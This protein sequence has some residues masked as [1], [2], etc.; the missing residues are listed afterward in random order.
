MAKAE[1]HPQRAPRGEVN[2]SLR[3][4]QFSPPAPASLPYASIVLVG[5]LTTSAVTRGDEPRQHPRRRGQLDSEEPVNEVQVGRKAAQNV[6]MASVSAV[7]LNADGTV[8][9]NLGWSRSRACCST[10]ASR[11]SSRSRRSSRNLDSIVYRWAVVGSNCL[12][13]ALAR[14]VSRGGYLVVRKSR[15]GPFPHFLWSPD[16]KRVEQYVPAEPKKRV[17]PPLIF[18]GYVKHGDN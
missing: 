14:W 1:C 9:K 13:F 16:L 3:R 8:K 15:W 10:P 7:V 4:W 6:R 11:S 18:K 17:I 5:S 12:V 2:P